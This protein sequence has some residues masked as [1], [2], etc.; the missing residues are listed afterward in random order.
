MRTVL[1]Y[2]KL[3]EQPFGV[4][5]D[6]RFLY[7]SGTHAEAMASAFYGIEAG[8]GFTALIAPPGMGKT[9]LLFELLRKYQASSKTV[10]IF[11][12]LSGPRDLLHTLLTDLGVEHGGE[13]LAGMHLKLNESLLRES[14]R[15]KRLIV[16]IDEAQNLE[17]P[18]L[19]AVRMLSNFETTREKL[20]H[21]ILAGQP[22]LAEKLTTA[23]LAQLRQRISIVSRLIPFNAEDTQFYIDHRLSVAGY[24]FV[25]PLFTPRASAMIAKNSEGIPRNISNICFN[26]MS[27]GSVA[28]QRTIDID[29]IQEVL[30]DLNLFLLFQDATLVR[31][32]EKPSPLTSPL[33]QPVPQAGVRECKPTQPILDPVSNE[34][35]RRF[36]P[37][38]S[39]PF[40]P[41]HVGPR[42]KN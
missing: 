14:R 19:E 23:R 5:P 7:V 32:P 31:D 17:D 16:V 24:D 2:Y 36:S 26:A 18:V 37:P 30:D 39:W 15:G 21:V 42:A 29:V 38:D 3:A 22:Q 8:R 13:D 4:T 10:F 6:P 9:T 28:K 11:Q 12:S 33:N 25:Q 34:R 27:L 40:D 20:M 1:D 41:D 35:C